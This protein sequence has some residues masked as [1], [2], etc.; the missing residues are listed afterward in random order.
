MKRNT[1][2]YD[3]PFPIFMK[4]G[5]PYLDICPTVQLIKVFKHLLCI[6]FP[7]LTLKAI[8]HK[9]GAVFVRELCLVLETC[10]H[11]SSLSDLMT[12]VNNRVGKWQGG[13][14]P[15]AV[16]SLTS[17]DYGNMIC[18]SDLLLI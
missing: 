3:R 2:A 15:C 9:L 5:L 10:A 1:T 13:Q 6:Y 17:K 7:C 12:I 8:I 4:P 16:S 14:M 18:V 11:T